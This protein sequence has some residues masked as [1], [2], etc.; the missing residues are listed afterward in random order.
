MAGK[1]KD[2]IKLGSWKYLSRMRYYSQIENIGEGK[3]SEDGLMNG[4]WIDLDDMYLGY[5]IFYQQQVFCRCNLWENI[6]MEKKL[7]DGI[8]N[9]KQ[10]KIFIIIN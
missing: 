10:E 5:L 4:N 7:E 2:G 8:S 9:S 3:Y 1:F 6:K